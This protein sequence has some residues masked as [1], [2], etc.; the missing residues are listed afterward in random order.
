MQESFDP[1]T[2]VSPW[3]AE[4]EEMEQKLTQAQAKLQDLRELARLDQMPPEQWA[5]LQSEIMALDE[6]MQTYLEDLNPLPTLFWQVV[7]FGGLGL[8]L[9]FALGRWLGE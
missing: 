7:R 5:E 4:L 2:P 9:G 3:L 1:S 8:V 6:R